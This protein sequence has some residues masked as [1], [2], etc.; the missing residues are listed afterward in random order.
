M[1]LWKEKKKSSRLFW[2]V[3][4]ENQRRIREGDRGKQTRGE[5]R[6]GQPRSR[7]GTDRRPSS[8]CGGSC[9]DT[10]AWKC[11]FLMPACP[12]ELRPRERPRNVSATHRRDIKCF[13]KW[14]D[15]FQMR[16]GS[17]EESLLSPSVGSQASRPGG[18]SGEVNA[19]THFPGTC[20]IYWKG[21]SCPMPSS[22]LGAFRTFALSGLWYKIPSHRLLS[23]LSLAA[24]RLG[25]S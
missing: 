5:G 3:I 14:L 22:L 2:S 6:A 20:N 4:I 18:Q 10:P 13:W 9:Q 16:T 7:Q 12:P 1:K 17:Q 11:L 19:R 21:Q 25:P 15:G 24:R 23:T 8:A